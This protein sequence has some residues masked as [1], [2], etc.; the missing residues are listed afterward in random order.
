M[1]KATR[2]PLLK[3]VS[4]ALL[5]NPLRGTLCQFLINKQKTSQYVIQPLSKRFNTTVATPKAP[6]KK[7]A[8]KKTSTPKKSASAKKTKKS[9]TKKADAPK[10]T[11]TKKV[12]GVPKYEVITPKNLFAKTIAEEVRS[13]KLHSKTAVEK[14]ISSKFATLSEEQLDQFKAE[15][16]KLKSK[17]KHKKL[18]EQLPPYY[19]AYIVYAKE[20]LAQIYKKGDNVIENM[21][22]VA[23]NWKK[24]SES[25]KE[26]YH[27]ISKELYKAY[28]EKKDELV[29]KSKGPLQAYPAFVK[30]RFGPYS[31]QHPGLTTPEVLISL[32]KEW[33]TLDK[34]EKQAFQSN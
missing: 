31:Q 21:K 7:Q 8:V 25:E 29:A 32:A 17:D 4:P 30:T 9:A 23:S 19:S 2:L 11:V 18:R 5:G 24:L 1:L 26:K 22:I 16:K 6:P 3:L 13:Q 10:K 33:K 15:S 12:F 28:K 14:Y 34:T 20:Q 27:D